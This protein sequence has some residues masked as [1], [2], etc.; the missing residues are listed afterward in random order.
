[1]TILQ[2]VQLRQMDVAKKATE[3]WKNR[4]HSRAEKRELLRE[5]GPLKADDVEQVQKFQ[6]R[7][8]AKRASQVPHVVETVDPLERIIG[9]ND[10]R[11]RP[12]SQLE[13]NAGSS[14]A[15]I[16]ELGRP[17][18]EPAGYGTGFVIAPGLL[19]TNNHVLPSRR[20]ARLS[21]ANM[22]YEKKDFNVERGQIFNLNPDRFF[23]TNE[24][25]DYTIVAVDELNSENEKLGNWGRL[26]LIAETGKTLVGLNIS[27]IQHPQGGHKRY[28]S[29]N[30]EIVDRL[31]DFL[32]YQTDTEPGSS[33]S[34]G[35]NH[36]WEVV[37][38]HHSGVWDED[39]EGKILNIY[40]QPWQNDQGLN[41]IKW[42]ANEG[43]RISSIISDL[44][45]IPLDGDDA[46]EQ[47]ELRD[48]ILG[49]TMIEDEIDHSIE[50]KSGS[51][52]NSKLAD[53]N[54]L[55]ST[56][57]VRQPSIQSS[58][59]INIYNAPV[60]I[61]TKEPKA[62][63]LMVDSSEKFASAT[64]HR[65]LGLE[66]RLVFDENY[67]RRQGYDPHFLN[68]FEIPFPKVDGDQMHEMLTDRY[69]N[70][71]ILDYHHYSLAMNE[72]WQLAVWT[73]ANADYSSK[74]RWN[75]SRE[76][77]GRDTWRTDPRI[78]DAIQIEDKELY[79]PAKKFDLGHIIR[80]VDT[81]W[82]ST[83]EEVVT[84]NS[85]TFHFTNCSPQH[86]RFNRS[87]LR[88]IWGKLENHIEQ[89]VKADNNRSVIFS[90]PILDPDKSI[91]HDFGGGQFRVPMEFWKIVV[92]AEPSDDSPETQLRAFGFI[93]EQ[94]SS[95]N[96][97][98]L[99][100][101]NAQERFELDEFAVLQQPISFIEKASGVMIPDIVKQADTR[102]S[103][104]S[105]LNIDSIEKVS[106]K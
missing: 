69:D 93:L 98:G 104:R 86:E 82:G 42:V 106:L 23:V 105:P 34:P 64:N 32:H 30:N 44:S 73:A 13:N 25:L 80:R 77:F 5:G 8:M 103:A 47:R 41:M 97:H 94:K 46:A 90:G 11:D 95:I 99:E 14:V 26:P 43:V 53:F 68:G 70:A 74:M 61:S 16:V 100:G 56:H 66:K 37:V 2:E 9:S 76:D 65:E 87:N 48:L 33:G 3:N 18:A 52:D 78:S 38:L 20:Q 36:L 27:I 19:I 102:K 79:K 91:L 58:G 40:N 55:Q 29:T 59:T 96:V 22:G 1:M 4:Y 24:E 17:G 15:R 75:I 83:R 71:L 63:T 28:A 88:G 67:S 84:A 101:L 6:Q 60:T 89:E 49:V 39:S 21:A 10:F 92:V 51:M 62:S 35:F 72:K 85:D 7:N 31:D 50:A 54:D 57:V 45:A 81:A 12:G